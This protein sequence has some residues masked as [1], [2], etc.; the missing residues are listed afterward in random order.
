MVAGVRVLTSAECAAQLYGRDRPH[1]YPVSRLGD[2]GDVLT[3]RNPT[4]SIDQDGL[5]IWRTAVRTHRHKCSRDPLRT[6]LN[7][8]V[9][10]T[11]GLAASHPMLN[12]PP[13]T[14]SIPPL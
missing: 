14:K 4:V 6:T 13:G 1:L 10:G 9:N 2:H 3:Q 8:P 7:K 12:S 11:A 5:S